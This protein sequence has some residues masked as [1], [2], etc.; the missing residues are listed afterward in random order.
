VKIGPVTPE[1]DLLKKFFCKKKGLNASRA[2]K[3]H[4]EMLEL[5]IQLY[6]PFLVEKKI[7]TGKVKIK[8]LVF[9]CGPRCSY[10]GYRHTNRG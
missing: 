7:T 1:F 4:Q 10:S 5:Y 6:S 3:I 2:K 9:F 8:W